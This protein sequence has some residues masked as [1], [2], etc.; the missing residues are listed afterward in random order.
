MT[1]HAY[2]THLTRRGE[3]ARTFAAALVLAATFAA[4]VWAASEGEALRCH[5]LIAAHN[6]AA[7][8]YCE[9]RR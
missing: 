6:P 3:W 7:S 9:G 5:R 1:A 4:L 2:R 8:T